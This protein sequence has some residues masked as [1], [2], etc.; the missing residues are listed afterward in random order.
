M[1]WRKYYFQIAYSNRAFCTNISH[2]ESIIF[3]DNK[4]LNK[5]KV[6]FLLNAMYFTICGS[7]STIFGIK[8]WQWSN[9]DSINATMN[10]LLHFPHEQNEVCAEGIQCKKWHF[11]KLY[12]HYYFT[13]S[14]NKWQVWSFVLNHR[15]TVNFQLCMGSLLMP[16]INILLNILFCRMVY[17]FIIRYWLGS[18][19]I[20][21]DNLTLF[22]TG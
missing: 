1:I 3:S 11:H 17:N 2:S 7:S 5:K 12:S 21:C 8:G 20:T 18:S 10:N 16:N 6:M 9:T 15:W 19:A 4:L 14:K 13:S 22:G